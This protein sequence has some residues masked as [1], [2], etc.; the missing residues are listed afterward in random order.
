MK[1]E[2]ITRENEVDIDLIKNRIKV[3]TK[4]IVMTWQ[5]S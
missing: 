4:E 2:G 3:G 5:N 1:I